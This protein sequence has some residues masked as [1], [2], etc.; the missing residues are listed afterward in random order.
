MSA[1]LCFN[2]YQYRYQGDFEV[3][4]LPHYNK[5]YFCWMVLVYCIDYERVNLGLI[6]LRRH[7]LDMTIAMTPQAP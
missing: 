2:F 1:P 6:S 4:A 7:S 3:Q 5:E